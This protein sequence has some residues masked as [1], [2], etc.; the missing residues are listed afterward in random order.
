MMFVEF[1][2]DVY[3]G[4]IVGENACAEDFDVNVVKEKHLINMCLFTSDVL[5]RLVPV[6]K[7]SLDQAL[8]FVRE[9]ECV[10]V[11]LAVVRL[12]KVE[13]SAVDRV[14]VARRMRA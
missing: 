4:M 6:R 3:E 5:V 10:E 11:M 9:D 2:E 13:L 1:G 12:C 7:L 8:E 14:K